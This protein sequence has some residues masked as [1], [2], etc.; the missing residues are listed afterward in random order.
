MPAN[1]NNEICKK[2]PYCNGKQMLNATLTSP[3]DVENNNSNTL[4]VFQ[5]PG[6]EEWNGVNGKRA[7]IVSSNSHS[8]AAR[9]RNSMNRKSVSRNEFDYA[10]TVQCYPGKYTSGRDKKPRKGAI[11]QCIKH[12]ETVIIEGEYNSIIA[13]GKVACSS[14]QNIADKNKLEISIIKAK[15]PS[16]GVTNQVLDGYY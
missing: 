4:F 12:L 5:A 16:S 3:I 1:F 9:I 13:F 14:V 2:C 10:E 11:N 7:P 8:A 15:H 6:I